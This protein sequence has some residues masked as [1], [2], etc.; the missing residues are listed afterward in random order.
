MTVVN[1]ITPEMEA[2]EQ[3]RQNEID[4][5][6]GVE[7]TGHERSQ[8]QQLS[9]EEPNI[10]EQPAA[11]KIQQSPADAER[12]RIA[13]R[14][15]R[16]PEDEKPFDGDMT[17]EENL[18]GTFAQQDLEPDPDAP[19]PGVP[20]VQQAE[21]PAPKMVTLKIRGKDVTMTEAEVLA[22]AAKV[23][24]AD[25]YLE[26]A[27]EL[28]SEAKRVKA[29]RAGRDPQHPEGRSSTQDDGQDI[30][31]LSDPQHP[32]DD[33]EAVV[34]KIQFGDPKE[35]ARDLR[36]VIATESQRQANE[37]HLQRLVSN[38]L[39]IAQKALADFTAANPHIANDPD[40]SVM[41]ENRI[42]SI[43]RDEI[44][45]LGVDEAKIPKDPRSLAD[46]HRWYRIHGDNVSKP[47]DLLIQ[48]GKH[49]E[50]RL[51]A[52][53]TK[54]AAK[55]KVAG[56]VEVNVD[57]TERRAAIPNQPTRAVAPRRDAVAAP[58][59]NPRSAAVAEMRKARG[60]SV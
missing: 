26:E 45:K 27:R 32:V 42:Y 50:S 29:E 38:D 58:V 43:Y 20:H 25:S 52:S 55:P 5:L 51:F 41:M 10:P 33:I 12:E 24:A 37:G 9:D 22:R 18:Y 11:K 39:A 40:A 15:K 47:A 28:L 31:P 59:Q 54:Q 1:E 49:V 7:D 6:T 60:Q 36:Q 44:A 19:E 48:A 57:R 13:N 30:D 35:A 21:A 23:D 14:F 2:A 3:E 8:D 46:W 56:R 16:G 17:N 4:A 34:E 53:T